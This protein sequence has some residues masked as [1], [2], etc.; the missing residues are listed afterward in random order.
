MFNLER[1]PEM[2]KEITEL[3]EQNKQ[4]LQLVKNLYIEWMG[5]GEGSTAAEDEKEEWKPVPI[6]GFGKY[7]E[8]SNMGRVRNHYTGRVLKACYTDA[9]KAYG[10]KHARV[11]L[12]CHGRKANS[13]VASLVV[14]AFMGIEDA[15]ITFIDRDPTNAALSNL[16]IEGG[17]PIDEAGIQ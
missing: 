6:H 9:M 5:V 4:I 7:Y 17:R 2:E 8:V 13:S 3:K 12:Q 14:K 1:I 15:Q 11:T 10:T 16:I